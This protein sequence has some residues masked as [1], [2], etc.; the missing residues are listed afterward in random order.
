VSGSEKEGK[1]QKDFHYYCVGVLARAAGF[2]RDDALT[3]AYASQYTDDSTESELIRLETDEGHLKFDPV[4]TSYSGLETIHSLAWSA[5]KRVWIPFHFLPPAPFRPEER[6]TFSFVTRPD[7]VFGR[8][9][10]DEAAKEPLENHNRRLCR[11]GVALHTYADSWS[12]Q[13]FSGRESREE[14]DVETISLRSGS[15][16]DWQKLGIENLLFDALPFIGHAEAG[17]FPDLAFQEWKCIVGGTR[18]VER[19][20][21][22]TFAEAA[23]TIYDRLLLMEKV[24]SEP[25]VP[26]DEIGPKVRM[27][28]ASQDRAPKGVER[29]TMPAYRSY[30]ALMVENRCDRWRK[31]FGYL[32]EPKAD[33]FRYDK[34]AWRRDA[35]TGDPDW[36]GYSEEEWNAMLPR[37]VRPGFWDSLWVNFHRA[38]LRQRHFVLEN[39]P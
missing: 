34:T 14:N 13:D 25:S 29:Y 39:L 21:I 5:Q 37:E 26:W 22:D 38:A 1:M 24:N 36:D 16:K 33:K 4:R 17:Y 3:I 28:L 9:L 2:N 11:I 35:I 20:N 23:Q 30:Q 12:H 6:Q 18:V 10:L 32:F 7:S 15:G 31:E 27:L 19:N 8:M